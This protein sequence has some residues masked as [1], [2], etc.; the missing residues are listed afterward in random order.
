MSLSETLKQY[1]T[2]PLSI[3][4]EV[5]GITYT[6]DDMFQNNFNGLLNNISSNGKMP[7]KEEL[8]KQA[9]YEIANTEQG[10]DVIS[11][12]PSDMKIKILPFTVVL[13]DLIYLVA[14]GTYLW[15]NKTISLKESIIKGN[16]AKTKEKD[17]K[18]ILIH[19]LRHA[20]Q[21]ALEGRDKN[22]FCRM[23]IAENFK[24]NKLCEA[25]TY[26]WFKTNLFCE[27]TFGHWANPTKEKIDAFMKRDLVAE[28]KKLFGVVPNP[29]FNENKIKQS[30]A[31]HFQQALRNNNGDVYAA[32][33]HLTG[34][35]MTYLMSDNVGLRDKLWQIFYHWQAFQAAR[36]YPR[37]SVDEKVQPNPEYEQ[38]LARF[39]SEYGVRHQDIDRTGLG[40]FGTKYL[41]HIQKS[42]DLFEKKVDQE[43]EISTRN[44]LKRWLDENQS[45]D[46]PLQPLRM[47]KIQSHSASVFLKAQMN[48]NKTHDR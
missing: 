31:Y 4:Q 12:L 20:N 13:K 21:H 1:Q 5:S 24:A 17:L 43:I 2:Q 42:W 28:K 32:Q 8:L 27:K 40:Y 7:P 23:S 11:R 38:I 48:R 6:K 34:Y 30:P 29:F 15:S 41:K 9:L 26:A 3:G 39:Q 45:D 33:K 35:Y 16:P 36:F 14:L 19:E 44:H 22:F 10:R 46:T 18:A 37:L 47:Q 25:E